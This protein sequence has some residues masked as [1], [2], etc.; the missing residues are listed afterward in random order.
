MCVE[1][2]MKVEKAYQEN[3][4]N[5]GGTGTVEVMN[6]GMGSTGGRFTSPC[7]VCRGSG[8]FWS[9]SYR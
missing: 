7:H 4:T 1:A 2:I 3:C 6:T 5:C 9:I 8:V